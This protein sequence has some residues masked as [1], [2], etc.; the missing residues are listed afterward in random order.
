M[1]KEVE[2]SYP[3]GKVGLV[4]QIDTLAIATTALEKAGAEKT[5]AALER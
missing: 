2:I 1:G 3:C 5:S 4:R